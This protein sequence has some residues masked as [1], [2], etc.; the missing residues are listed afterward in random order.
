MAQ[1]EAQ[2]RANKKYREKNKEKT[3]IGRYRTTT[4]TFIRNHAE[5]KDLEEIK[6]MVAEREKKLKEIEKNI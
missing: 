4:R 6:E 3:R 5:M 1:T 2:K